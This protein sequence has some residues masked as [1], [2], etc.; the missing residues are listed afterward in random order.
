MKNQTLAFQAI[1]SDIDGTLLTSTIQSRHLPGRN[2]RKLLER[3]C[4][5]PLSLQEALS[6]LNQS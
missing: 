3:D 2:Y 1:F 5:L 4:R 6:V